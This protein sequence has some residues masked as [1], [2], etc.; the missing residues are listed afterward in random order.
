M[1]SER[2]IYCQLCCIQQS[3]NLWHAV[4]CKTAKWYGIRETTPCH[5]FLK[6]LVSSTLHSATSS[7]RKGRDFWGVVFCVFNL[8]LQL[9]QPLK[10]PMKTSHTE[11]QLFFCSWRWWEHNVF[12]KLKI[13]ADLRFYKGKE[14]ESRL[15]SVNRRA[16][17]VS[18]RYTSEGQKGEKIRFQHMKDKD[19]FTR[20]S[21]GFIGVLWEQRNAVGF[22]YQNPL[23]L[24]PYLDID[25]LQLLLGA[26]WGVLKPLRAD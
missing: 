13:R 2:F 7:R 20:S 17:P 10:I 18:D 9:K 4:A 24:Q 6:R 5:T 12:M 1:T 23:Q 3:F 19:R 21:Q 16:H 15:G 25:G 22:G 14:W 11:R 26:P 8:H